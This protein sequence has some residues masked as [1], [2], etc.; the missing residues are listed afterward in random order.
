M[1]IAQQNAKK[2]YVNPFTE[3]Y[4]QYLGPK[5]EEICSEFKI[6][7]VNLRL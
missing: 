7:V 3:N 6:V 5:G 1:A 2:F 4:M